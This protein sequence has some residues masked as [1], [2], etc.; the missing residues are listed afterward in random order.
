MYQFSQITNSTQPSFLTHLHINQTTNT[1]A[2]YYCSQYG[3]AE[4][5]KV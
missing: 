2:L 3:T 5:G 1:V 4:F